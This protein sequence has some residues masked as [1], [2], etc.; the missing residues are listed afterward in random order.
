MQEVAGRWIKDEER[1]VYQAGSESEILFYQIELLEQ[2]KYQAL[3]IPEILFAYQPPVLVYP[4]AQKTA[5]KDSGYVAELPQLLSILK[6]YCELRTLMNDELLDYQRILLDEVHIYL[7]QVPGQALSNVNF[8]YL[9]L[10]DFG[11]E[12]NCEEL[13]QEA[14]G[15]LVEKAILA[16]AGTGLLNDTEVAEWILSSYSNFARFHEICLSLHLKISEQNPA[17]RS[18]SKLSAGE[19]GRAANPRA[20]NE[21]MRKQR[22][23][24]NRT[25]LILVG[26]LICS[27]L[28]ANLIMQ[29]EFAGDPL[30][31]KPMAI[32]FLV[33]AIGAAGVAL[34]HPRSPFHEEKSRYQN[35]H[36]TALAT[37][38]NAEALSGK[39][40]TGPALEIQNKRIFPAYLMAVPSTQGERLRSK[41]EI[42]EAEVELFIFEAPLSFGADPERAD[43]SFGYKNEA[44]L[45]S[46][47]Y[48]DETGGWLEQIDEQTEIFINQEAC[49][50]G[51]LQRLPDHCLLRIGPIVREFY[52]EA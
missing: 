33:L 21:Q 3:L 37:L 7:E 26:G 35:E 52:R 1:L 43:Y 46:R 34:F 15:R 27:L 41:S 9:P 11:Q 4:L 45:H 36:E 47:V 40:A 51:E 25:G 17:T 2:I 30:W 5:F 42:I 44:A 10:K 12:D 16:A 14:L 50:M 48:S 19:R 31:P 22:A 49:L 20:K 28:V 39:A 8:I 23:P 13:Q 32:F 6:Q 18:K 38:L 29:L 24:I